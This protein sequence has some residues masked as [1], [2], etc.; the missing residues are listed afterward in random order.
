MPALLI[1]LVAATVLLGYPA[2]PALARFRPFADHPGAQVACWAGLLLGTVAATTAL[3]T[4]ALFAPPT[5]GHG[6]LEWLQ[7]CLPHHSPVAFVLGGLA[8]LAILGA[9]GARLAQGLPRL[10]RSLRQRR[11]H[12]SMLHLVAREDHRNADVLLLDHPLPVAYCL[13]SR[14]RP[15]VLSTGAQARLTDLQLQAVLAHERAHLRQRHHALLLFLDL[16]HT[17]LSWLPTVRRA[18][19]VLPTLL[20]M[21]AD[22]AAARRWGRRTLAGALRQVA[23]TPGLAGALAAAGP[24][25]GP[26]SLRLTRLE[27]AVPAGPAHHTRRVLAWTVAAVTAVVPVVTAAA[28]L[29]SLAVV[30]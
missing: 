8:S 1:G 24:G 29:S 10:W 3:I 12:R 7:D 21:S 27:T 18:K 5:P 2:G 23:A 14:W 17:L 11:D 9:C 15:I 22:D 28:A 19:A 4:I 20:E 6:V 30:C 26:L 16:T 25:D 13:P